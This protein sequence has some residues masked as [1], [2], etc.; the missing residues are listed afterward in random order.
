MQQA[1]GR[2]ILKAEMLKWGFS[3]SGFTFM[4]SGRG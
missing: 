4:I 1:F 3:F 2:Q